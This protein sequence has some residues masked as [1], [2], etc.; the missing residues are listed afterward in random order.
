[1]ACGAFSSTFI[2]GHHLRDGGVEFVVLAHVL[3]GLLDG[4]VNGCD[5]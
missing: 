3:A 1:V 5:E 4:Q 2:S